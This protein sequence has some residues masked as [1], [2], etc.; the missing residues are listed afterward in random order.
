LL[1]NPEVIVESRDGVG[2]ITFNRPEQLNVLT[3][4]L[5]VG[6]LAAL[7]EFAEDPSVLAVALTGSGRAFSAGG[8]LAAGLHEITGTGSQENQTSELRR[9]MRVSQLLVEMPKPTIAVINGAC[10]GGSLGMACSA[11]IRIAS[12]NAFFVTAFLNAGVSG[13][14]AGSWGLS[15][16]VGPGVAREL[17]LTG[18]RVD[19]NLALHLG[20]VSE[21]VP[22][23]QL[24]ERAH[25]LATELARRPPLA[26]R[27]MKEIFNSLDGELFHRVLELEA[28][29]QVALINSDDATE[30]RLAFLSK[31][32][33]TYRGS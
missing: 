28:R 19:A 29:S 2:W 1:D 33:A 16:A 18:R 8:N 9:F 21:V 7:E 3:R 27:A 26:I 32:S 31:R 11:D 22:A 10:A 15:R 23:D 30:A 12:E 6:L 5:L 4:S 13:D 14:F 25:A 20:L 17:Y 24:R